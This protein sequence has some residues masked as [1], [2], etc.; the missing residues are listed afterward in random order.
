MGGG[1]L[2]ATL[3]DNRSAWALA[4]E[5]SKH[6]VSLWMYDYCGVEKRAPLRFSVP[7]D[8][9]VTYID[10]GDV[11]LHMGRQLGVQYAPFTSRVTILGHVDNA[12]P[13]QLREA[14]S[15]DMLAAILTL[16]R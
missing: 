2:L 10:P 5:L 1:T 11:V 3:A 9:V 7:R 15:G 14:L 8:D 6:H 12:T 13:E 4:E 16:E